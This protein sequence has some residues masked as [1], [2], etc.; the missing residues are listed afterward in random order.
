MVLGQQQ[1]ANLPGDIFLGGLFPV[2]KKSDNP[3][4]PCGPIQG[5]RGIQRLEAMFFTLEEINNKQDLLPNITLGARIIDTCSRD[6]Y[7]VEQ[8]MDFIRAS[9]RSFSCGQSDA[10]PV[11]AVIGGS[12]S[13]VSIQVVNERK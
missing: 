6:T 8:S 13:S 12:Y 4:T 10:Q 11:A 2:H 9:M 7:A 3:G 5:E 1:I